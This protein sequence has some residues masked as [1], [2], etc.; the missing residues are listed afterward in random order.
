MRSGKADSGG[1]DRIG[2]RQG[3]PRSPY[4][5][6]VAVSSLWNRGRVAAVKRGLR[7]G[8]WDLETED[9]AEGL[10]G[11]LEKDVV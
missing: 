5:F 7:G 11:M 6:S 2:T 3:C 1:M 9:V 10:L 4:L 8:P